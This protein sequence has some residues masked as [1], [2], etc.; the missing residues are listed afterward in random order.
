MS[1]PAS[2]GDV[3]EA[4]AVQLL[5]EPVG[6]AAVRLAQKALDHVGQRAIEAGG[7]DIEP[8][9][10]V[11]VPCPARKTAVG[12]IDAH[13][14]LTVGEG[15]VAIVMKQPAGLGV[16]EEQVGI[17]VVVVIDPGT[18]LAEVA[19]VALHAG[20]RGDF[21]EGAVALV[22]VEAVGLPLAADIE[23][24][25]AIVIII[26]PGGRVGIDRVQQPSFAGDID[27]NAGAVFRR[28]DGR[29]G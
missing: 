6:K 14:R 28:S 17:A 18:S 4:L 26:G 16:V 2:L 24:D 1:R 27:E 13:G 11:V 19:G 29:M 9:V 5:I 22:V 21:L 12:P 8:A 7:E 10:V 23:V 3:F 20:L 15:S 25:K